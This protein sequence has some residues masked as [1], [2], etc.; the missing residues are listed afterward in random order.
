LFVCLFVCLFVYFVSQENLTAE[1]TVALLDD[2]RAGKTPKVG[3]QNGQVT[4]E[5]PQGRTTLKDPSKIKVPA[6]DFAKLK[7][8][9]DQAKK[10]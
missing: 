4:C 6:R 2:L 1:T 8:E 3:P 10:E 7:A 9:L 5:G